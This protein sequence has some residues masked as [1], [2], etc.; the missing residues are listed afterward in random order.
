MGESAGFC[1][2]KQRIYR[3]IEKTDVVDRLKRK[4]G[5]SGLAKRDL[6]KACDCVTGTVAA[7]AS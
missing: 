7:P 3:G 2:D 5:G 1:A 6:E 4:E